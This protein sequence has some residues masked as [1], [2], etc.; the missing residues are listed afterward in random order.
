MVASALVFGA[1][2][3]DFSQIRL[4]QVIQGAARR[5]PW[6]STCVALWKQEPRDPARDRTATARTVVPRMR[7][8]ELS[9]PTDAP[10][11]LLLAVGLGTAAF[12]MQD[13]LLE[14]YG[15]EDPRARGRR[16]DHAHRDPAPAARWSAS[17]SPHGARR[18]AATPAASPASAR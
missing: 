13:I 6:C 11:R 15:G 2:L 1:L 14:P 5:R 3:S 7:W 9:R 16:D 4:I 12:S 17:R 10:A 8:R 18:A